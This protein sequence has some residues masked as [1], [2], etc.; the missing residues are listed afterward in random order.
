VPHIL[1]NEI[2]TSLSTLKSGLK[3][4][5]G[6]LASNASLSSS[7]SGLNSSNALVPFNGFQGIDLQN[8][9]IILDLGYPRR[10]L[11]T[12]WV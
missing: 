1:D 12:W 2:D 8:M 11:T 7:R 9:G 5:G 3:N 10:L 6:S 4:L